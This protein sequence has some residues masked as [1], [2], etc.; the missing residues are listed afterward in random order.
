MTLKEFLA[1]YY[2]T[3]DIQNPDNVHL[4][5]I[6]KAIRRSDNQ[7]VDSVRTSID[8]Q[9]TNNWIKDS[10][11]A[12]SLSQWDWKKVVDQAKRAHLDYFAQ[13]APIDNY[14]PLNK[15]ENPDISNM[16]Q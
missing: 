15:E 12:V 3:C 8:I 6:S 1:K 13:R 9:E 5:I 2:C 14:L 7:V 11:T 16:Y 10:Q 4:I